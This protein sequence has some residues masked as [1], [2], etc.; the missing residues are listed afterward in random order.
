MV[1]RDHDWI[2]R[3]LSG[4]KW[5]VVSDNVRRRFILNSYRV[6]LSRAREG[7]VIWVPT[8]EYTD[9]TRQPEEFEEVAAMLLA[10]GAQLIDAA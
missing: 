5:N 3:S 8:G 10:S 2:T 9:H 6:L 4:N 7:M 1:Y